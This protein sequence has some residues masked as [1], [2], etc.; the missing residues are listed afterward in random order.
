VPAP[1]F[2]RAWSIYAALLTT[3]VVVG[4]VSNLWRGERFSWLTVA[5]WIVTLA[6]LTATWGYAMQRS[7][8]NEPY[9]RRVFWI[10]VAVTVL[11]LLRV[12]LAS[13]AALVDVL[14]FMTLLVPAY[15]AAFRYAFRSPQLWRRDPGESPAAFM[16]GK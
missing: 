1:R 4:E 5:N 16:E 2:P 8:G 10:L 9:W 11:M 13:T 7:I 6:L 3:A 12:A 14:G 15:V